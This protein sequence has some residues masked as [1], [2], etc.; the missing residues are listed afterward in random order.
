MPKPTRPPARRKTS[1]KPAGRVSVL[2]RLE[3]QQ[4]AALQQEAKRRRGEPGRRR[5]DVSEVLREAV[6]VWMSIRPAQRAIIRAVATRR[7]LTRPE[8][9][10]EAL[11]AWLTSLDPDK[12]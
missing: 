7:E 12:L 10:R 8:V 3:A 1:T 4:V 9:L 5:A 6:S 11:D 2:A